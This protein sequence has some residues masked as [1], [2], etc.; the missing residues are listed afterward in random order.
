MTLTT[1][2]LKQYIL[3]KPETVEDYPFGSD[4][5]VF[6]VLGK[7]FA[8]LSSKDG[9]TNLNLKCDPIEASQLRDLFE[10]VKPGYHMNKKHWNTIIIDGSLPKGEIERMIDN[11][12]SLVVKGLNKTTRT[13]L[14][15]RHGK[16][17]I[18]KT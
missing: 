10:A 13:G 9:I 4:V 8:L 7:M 6:K 14:E 2:K 17:V 18:Y 12:Y 1:S 16:A 11:S 15:L 5:A 3:T